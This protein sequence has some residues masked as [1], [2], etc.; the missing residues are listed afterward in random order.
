[1]FF[2]DT[3]ICIFILNGK[4]P[5]L[6]KQYL[7]CARGEIGIPTVVLFELYYGAE[8]SKSQALNRTKIQEF[9]SEVEIVSFDAHAAEIAGKIRA[10]LER[11]GKIIGN[12]DLLI[13][14]TALAYNGVV[15][16]NNTREFS[17]IEGLVVEDWT[18]G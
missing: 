1:M 5:D 7:K 9:I 12:N 6:N 14:A 10:D 17:R 16:T 15:V 11:A 8:K 18:V 2:L 3:N 13:S 4:Y